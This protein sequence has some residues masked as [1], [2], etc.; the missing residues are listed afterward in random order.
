MI[1]DLLVQDQMLARLG[2][3]E[4]G[5]LEALDALNRNAEAATE[6]AK[7]YGVDPR[8]LRDAADILAETSVQ[9]KAAKPEPG[10][11]MP[12]DRYGSIFQSAIEE[13]Y[14]QQDCVSQA[15]ALGLDE[16]EADPLSDEVLTSDPLLE[17]PEA[18]GLEPFS[19]LDPRWVGA[20][21]AAKFLSEAHG[22]YPFPDDRA[23]V[24]PLGEKARLILVG[25]WATGIRRAQD[26]AQW[27]GQ[28]A[29]DGVKQGRDTHVISLGDVY[30]AGFEHEYRDRF[31]AY[32]PVLTGDANKIHSWALNANH[33]MY[34]GGFG[35][36]D[37]MLADPRFAAQQKSSYFLLENEN[38]QIA[39][40]DSAYAPPDPKGD[41]GNLYGGQ[42]Q[43]L[44][45]Q[46]ERAPA[47]RTMLLT[48]HQLFSSWE[49]NAP[50][51]EKAL[52]GV[53]QQRKI[54][55]WFWGH[56]HRCAVYRDPRPGQPVPFASLI[57]HGGVPVKVGA[58]GDAQRAPLT[59]YYQDVHISGY[60]YLGFVVVDLDG[61]NW[62]AVYYN[63]RNIEHHRESSA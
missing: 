26:V 20:F 43:W 14:R 10:A 23:P 52:E 47:K 37:L 3:V 49:T 8:Q 12:R 7:T 35:Y 36:F 54:D 51:M 58:Q 61:P 5:A 13:F 1:R 62:T 21:L 25:D 46:R 53:F 63:E 24:L 28:H 19:T 56:E 11:Y 44:H 34:T 33:D 2:A 15:V 4:A 60:Q 39:G 17:P 45:T 57:G 55:A 59:Y 41:R 48:H 9:L 32:W 22:T 30:Y 18:L 6:L 31:L 40:L 38:W 50:L 42:A 16:G 29:Q 27:M